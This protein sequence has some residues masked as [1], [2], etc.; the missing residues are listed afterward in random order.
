MAVTILGR[1]DRLRACLR[2]RMPACARARVCVCVCVRACGGCGGGRRR[3][4]VCC[5]LWLLRLLYVNSKHV[6]V[7]VL[8]AYVCGCVR[9][10]VGPSCVRRQNAPTRQ[11]RL[12]R[13]WRR[14]GR[15]GAREPSGN[16]QLWVRRL[17]RRGVAVAQQFATRSDTR[18][19]SVVAHTALQPEKRTGCLRWLISC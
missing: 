17:P 6:V 4:G 19:M 5:L 3:G 1:F 13:G 10:C 16:E 2:A 15:A 9:A 8:V 7:V 12:L 14:T 18:G 11:E